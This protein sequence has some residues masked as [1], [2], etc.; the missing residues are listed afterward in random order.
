M[1]TSPDME[2]VFTAV[3]AFLV[4]ILPTGIPVVKSLGNR[5]PPP[6]TG[7]VPAFAAMTAVVIDRLATNED[8]YDDP[9][10]PPD[11]PDTPGSRAVQTAL[12]VE[13]QLDLYGPDAAL[14]A[15]RVE[16]FWRD[17]VGCALLAP[18]CQPLHA[19]RGMLAPLTSGEEQYVTRYIVRAA[20]QWNPV[21][22]LEQQFAGAAEVDL[23]SVDAQYPPT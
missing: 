19:D 14:W 2:A 1:S 13:M 7:Q 21:S 6:A 18:S 22:T 15:A 12:Q 10:A 5:V 17:D 16:Q 11:P 9:W 8:A 20:L 4:A 23:I 3:R